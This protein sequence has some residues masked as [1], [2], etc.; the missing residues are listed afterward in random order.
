MTK[1][2][3]GSKFRSFRKAILGEDWRKRVKEVRDQLIIIID[4]AGVSW[5]E[6]CE[7][8]FVNQQHR[9]AEKIYLDAAIRYKS[10][11]YFSEYWSSKIISRIDCSQV[12]LL[13]LFKV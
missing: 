1:P 6:N 2:L 4:S 3:Q 10:S 7:A 12:I 11:L 5:I 13:I 8:I 9:V